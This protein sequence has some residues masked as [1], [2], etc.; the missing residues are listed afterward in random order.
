MTK[1]ALAKG[2]MSNGMIYVF[3]GDEA[4]TCEM[5]DFATHS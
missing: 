5:F 1:R 2:W 3:G 4:D